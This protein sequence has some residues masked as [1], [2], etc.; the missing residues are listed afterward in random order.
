MR[1]DDVIASLT[2]ARE[3]I[4]NVRVV[5]KMPDAITNGSFGADVKDILIATD[6]VET[7]PEKVVRL[8]S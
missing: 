1:I 8:E 3:R 5:L 2:E 7:P 4:G 6:D